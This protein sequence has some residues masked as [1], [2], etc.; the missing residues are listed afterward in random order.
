MSIIFV[1]N[2]VRLGVDMANENYYVVEARLP[3]QISEASSP[4]EAGRKAARIIENQ[5]G[6]NIS[7]WY[8]RVFEYGAG[9]DSG[10]IGEYFCNPAG[11]KFRKIDANI[12]DHE[13]RVKSEESI[14]D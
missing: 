4:E 6:V 8:L 7:N 9:E 14:A 2:V 1:A 12:E 5:Y 11:T 10:P 3:I 13:E